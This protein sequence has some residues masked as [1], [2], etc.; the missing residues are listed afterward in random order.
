M[1]CNKCTTGCSYCTPC[2]TKLSCNAVLDCVDA[3]LL[4][5]YENTNPYLNYFCGAA[6]KCV[7]DELYKI[8]LG[9]DN[10]LTN[11][12]A[13]L[14]ETLRT[15]TDYSDSGTLFF[16]VEDG[17]MKWQTVTGSGSGTV[18]SVGLSLPTSVFTVTNSPVTVS[19]TLTGTFKSQMANRVFAGPT[20][21]GPAVP[22][23]RPLVPE[24]LDIRFGVAGEDDLATQQRLFSGDNTYNV[25]FDETNFIVRGVYTV[26]QT[27]PNYTESQMFF[28]PLKAAFRAGQGTGVQYADANIGNFSAAFGANV[29]ANADYAMGW[30]TSNFAT[31]VMSTAFGNDTTAS[32]SR[33]TAWGLT[34]SALGYASTAWGELTISNAHYATAHGFGTETY[35]YSGTAIG[36]YNDNTLSANPTAFHVS[37]RAFEV[38]IG[39]SDLVRANALTVLFSGNVGVGT[40]LPAELLS[41]GSTGVTKGVLSFAGN[42]SGKVIIQ[43]KAIA[44]TYTLTLPDTDGSP[45]EFLTTDGTGI[46]SW[47]T[48]SGG[49]YTD[50][51]AQD[52][53]GNQFIDT[54]TINS[55]Y[56]DGGPSY[57]WDV[58]YQDSLTVN[59]SDDASGLKADVI[60]GGIDNALTNLV[61]W[62][63]D[64]F[65]LRQVGSLP[66]GDT[67]TDEL[68]RV[69]ANDTTSGY[70]NG[71]LVAGTNIVFTENNDGANET[72][73]ISATAVAY[74][75][76]QAQ[77]AVGSNFLDTNTIDAV[78]VDGTPSF[79]WNVR[80]Q[81]SLTNTIS[82]DGS[83][84]QV[85]AIVGAVDNTLMNVVMWDGNEFKLRQVATIISGGAADGDELVKVSIDDTTGGYLT[86]KLIAGTGITL[87][88]TTPGGNETYVIAT[89]ITQY[90]DELA[91][92][93][94]NAMA[95]D[96]DTINYTYTDGTPESKWDVR[97]QMSI[98]SDSSGLKLVND[99]TTPGATRY[100][101]TDGA[102]AKGWHVLVPFSDEAAQDAIGT[103]VVDTNTVN[104]TYTD[105]TPE[106]KWDV[107]YQD[108]TTVDLSDDGS[109]LKAD[110]ITDTS[111]QKVAVR[112]NSTG[113][114]VGTRRRLNFVEGANITLTITDD[115]VDNE[116]DIVI[117][118][119]GGGGGGYD[120]IQ[121]EGSNLTQRQVLNFVGS[122][123]TAA[124]DAG[125]VRTNVSLDAD[126]NAISQLGTTG[127]SARTAAN[128]WALRSIAGGTGIS[129]ADGD[130]VAGNP[131]IT[132]TDLGSSQ[133]IFKNIAV[134][135]QS[136][137]VADSNNDT[138]TL[139][140][141][142]NIVLTTNAGTDSITITGTGGGGGAVPISSLQPAV[143]VNDIDN[144]G[145]IQ[146]WRWD[147][148]ADNYGLHIT[149][150][151]TTADDSQTLMAV[152]LSGANASANKD[153]YALEVRN[154]HTG[155]NSTNTG[156]YVEGSGG[157]DN[158]SIIAIG[159]AGFGTL[160][161]TANVHVESSLRY[162]DGNEAVGYV[163]TSDANGNA[164]W[165]APGSGTGTVTS[166]AFTDGNGFDGT[167][168]NATTTPTLSLTT[169]VGNTQIMYSNSGAIA[170]SSN[171][172][173]SGQAVQLT[174]T[175]TTQISSN[176]IFALQGNS[177]T[178]GT[179][180]HASSSSLTTGKLVDLAVSG[181]AANG[182]TVLTT[183]TSGANASGSMTSYSAQF[184]NTHTGTASTNIAA[185]FSAVNGT[186]NYAILVASGEGS[187]GIGTLT[188]ASLFTVGA[189]QFQVVSTGVTTIGK[190]GG[191]TGLINLKGTTSGT[192]GITTLAAAGTWTLTLPNTDGNANEYLKTDGS[193]N[194]SWSTISNASLTNSSISFAVGTT[195]TDV[196]W[197]TSP[198]SLGGTATIN[199]PDASVTARGVV[200]TGAQSF[201]GAKTF[202]S[203][204]IST[205]ARKVTFQSVSA[206][207]TLDATDEITAVSASGAA[208]IIT[209]PTAVGIAGRVY[210][211]KKIDSSANTVTIDGNGSQTI[212]GSTTQ[213]LYA[214]W[215]WIKII[216]DGAN[217]L[218][219][220]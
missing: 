201:I 28:N 168:T 30:G 170:G 73:T 25:T 51:Q 177:L 197:T 125:G 132:N 160:S 187:V 158:R 90:T 42:T 208:R 192:V 174:S 24:D 29:I 93:A 55:T 10:E 109:G 80:Y 115:V 31:G 164:S 142:S 148:L 172:T 159:Y 122:G 127:L 171:W 149:S 2:L 195:G 181:I 200:T 63:G 143:A 120:T 176:S 126:L 162:V 1:S 12:P 134:S 48:V 99:A 216:S 3:D 69:S 135:G 86:D 60:V 38:G 27:I 214:Q 18:T 105:G 196:T 19:G 112:K 205:A 59:L 146:V 43:P 91:Q 22:T 37:N 121:E 35:S 140:A 71:K 89:S 15:V 52:A 153:T 13:A 219:I 83:G 113:G 101:G 154:T 161:P 47:S 67:D 165:A 23:F 53:V 150:D 41:L 84:L 85:D 104:V 211:I 114:D 58:R 145:Y 94:F 144:E 152:T 88:E 34:T 163:L 116:V 98:T 188:P 49:T 107:R 6:N 209:L 110:V 39:T 123:F 36:Q 183:T 16:S 124:D 137:V 92:D 20:S 87:T 66:S 151:S 9:L 100:Y 74:T 207:D 96:T 191:T 14:F 68:A 193:G 179:G 64:E 8:S 72:L 56:T 133:N 180:F 119:T 217:W 218:I 117:T 70:L 178:T 129:V 199:I 169:T 65:K 136:T 76:E 128:T 62:D 7:N 190:V 156:L 45:G 26:G 5:I 108:S 130:G 212:D 103:M 186:N 46:L 184:N 138:L 189:D 75:D 79:A 141:G 157:S 111:V 147:T 95:I 175:N 40:T 44:G 57:S 11:F 203:E 118:G 77:D 82:D 54:N 4:K 173:F 139:V 185:K 204:L 206:D 32:G 167:V 210:T 97:Y 155:T 166:F 33:S 50:E 17:E 182:S 215:D 198:V 106:L 131:T 21:G 61:V 194:T 213:V 102:G 202:T 81:D 78:Y 220:G